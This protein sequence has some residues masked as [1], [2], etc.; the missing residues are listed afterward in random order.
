MKTRDVRFTCGKLKLEGV[1]YYPDGAGKF[2]GVVLCHPHPMY[3]GSMINN[4]ILE[5]ATV[6]PLK[7]IIALMFNFRSVGRSQGSFDNGTGEQEDVKA[8][9]DWLISQPEVDAG[10]IGVA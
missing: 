7:G 4:V 6:L 2:P 5:L 10:R 3:G 9:I 8:A 1:C